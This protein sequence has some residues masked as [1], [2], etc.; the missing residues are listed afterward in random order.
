MF[1]LQKPTIYITRKIPEHLLD[2]Y[3]ER[4]HFRMYHEERKPIPKD[5]LY[6]EVL[7]ADGLLCLLTEQIDE[8]FLRHAK[9]LKI[10][11]NMAVGYDNIDVAA[12]EKY[13]IVVT[14]TPDVLTET[15][16]DLTFALLMATAR[17]LVQSSNL[18]YQNGWKEWS[19]FDMV[20]TDVY[21]KTIGIVGMGRIGTAVARR[22]KG[23]DMDILYH[24]R[25]RNQEVEEVLGAEYCSFEELLERADFVVSLLP[26][27]EK[28]AKKFNKEAFERMKETA[29][30][31]NVSRGGV[32]DEDALYEALKE[33]K[34]K[35]AGLDVFAKE[36]IDSSHPFTKLDNVLL[37]PHI[38]SSTKETREKMLT[39]CLD[40]LDNYFYGDGALTPVT[41][42]KK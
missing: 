40:N 27:T 41:K 15:T 2:P 18:I 28:T 37:T 39:L 12:A 25:S 10:I 16:A 13:G 29:I 1:F 5:M 7:E 35:A 20:G 34:I 38:G 17:R 23:F 36:P 21:G 42:N 22:A 24:N 9:H 33:G 26:L 8:P 31:I 30:F 6:E 11:A 14:N 4:F 3:R 19:P 32:V